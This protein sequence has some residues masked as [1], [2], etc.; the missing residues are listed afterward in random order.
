MLLINHPCFWTD[1]ET[2]LF[3]KLDFLHLQQNT[4]VIDF[5]HQILTN[6]QDHFNL[7]K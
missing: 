3:L 5:N 6:D 4:I 2:I 1:R 7:R